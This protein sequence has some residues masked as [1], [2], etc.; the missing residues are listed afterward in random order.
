YFSIFN[1]TAL[2]EISGGGTTGDE[3]LPPGVTRGLYEGY[4]YIWQPS[5][6]GNQILRVYA[7]DASGNSAT[8]TWEI[9]VLSVQTILI[10][11]SIIIA[12]VVVFGIIARAVRGR[13][14]RYRATRTA[15]VGGYQ[16]G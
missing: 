6:E 13:K 4:Y 1:N 16:W 9:T 8:E 10:I 5:I 2:V 15:S 3:G 14:K 12:V 11:V 7:E